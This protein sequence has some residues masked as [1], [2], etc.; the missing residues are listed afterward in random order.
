MKTIQIKSI[1]H[2]IELIQMKRKQN[3]ISENR[4]WQK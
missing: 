3:C 2:E 1:K 4:D